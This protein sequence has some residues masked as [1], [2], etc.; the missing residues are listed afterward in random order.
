MQNISVIISIVV[1]CYNQAVYLD[2]C[3]QSVINQ[4]FKNWECII[5]DDGSPDNT[6]EVARKWLNEDSRFKYIYKDNGGLSSARNA[7]IKFAKGEWILPLDADDKISPDYL[8]LASEHI[9]NNYAIIYC[10][11]EYFGTKSGL[12]DLEEF[13]LKEMAFKNVIFCSGFFKKLDWEKVSG[14]D[15]NLLGGLEDWEFWI[16][17]LKNNPN[18][19]KIESICF[20]YRIKEDSM[21]KDLI[22]NQQVTRSSLIYIYKK[23]FDFF[24]EHLGLFQDLIKSQLQLNDILNSK[25]Y[26]LGIFISKLF[27]R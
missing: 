3:L 1:P 26:K 24:I 2:E 14:Y 21:V 20:Y 16:S 18:V 19:Y 27:G 17:L 4:E 9:N 8:S 12:W 10:Q 11:A 22:L 6:E 25:R 5:V 7:G 13:S 23:H 15:E